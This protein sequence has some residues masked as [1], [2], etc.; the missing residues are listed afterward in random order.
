MN[1]G[2]HEQ[3]KQTVGT[4]ICMPDLGS[5]VPCFSKCDSWSCSISIPWELVRNAGS[6]ADLSL[7]DQNL[8]LMRSSG[9][10]SSALKFE[11]T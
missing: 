10:P 7:S 6:Q 5:L 2:M 11:Q 8:Y 3:I 9:D 4:R 1:E